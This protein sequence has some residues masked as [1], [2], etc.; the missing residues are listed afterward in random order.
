VTVTLR[1]SGTRLRGQGPNLAV[2]EIWG[3]LIVYNALVT[4]AVAAAVT[5][6]V[7]PDEISFT[8][9]LALTRASL[10]LDTPC[11]NCGC[12]PS[13]VVGPLEVLNAAIT[14]Q[15]RNRTDRQRTAPRTKKER[16]AEHT[17]DV[18]YL[19]KVVPSTLA[20]EDETALS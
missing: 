12:R 6:D 17:R 7:D 13:D 19:I 2:Q 16:Q 8:A 1:G 10:A 14:A 4:L 11:R 15:P 9:V 18:D 5:L 3:L 20:R